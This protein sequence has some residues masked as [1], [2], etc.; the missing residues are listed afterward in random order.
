M[1]YR[2]TIRKEGVP[3]EARIIEAP[4][5]FAVYEQAQKE[6]GVVVE[7]I[8]EGDGFK[9]PAWLFMTIGTGVKR[10]EI[11]RMAKNLS[12]M[13]SA[14]LSLSRALSVI[15]RQSDNKR[16]RA[17]ATGISE[18]IKKGSS[19]HEALAQGQLANTVAP[20]EDEKKFLHEF[21]LLTL[22]P[23]LYLLN[24]KFDL[25]K[26]DFATSQTVIPAI[27]PESRIRPGSRIKF[28]MTPE[29]VTFD[30]QLYRLY[31]LYGLFDYPFTYLLFP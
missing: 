9:M 28:G 7:L 14:G 24:D 2:A 1:K 31:G 23:I 26:K 17:V 29:Y 18:S 27:E 16:L 6:D 13:L 8:E 30:F 21:P 22:K 25:E 5:R 20:S 4:S 11:I 3:D 19:F 10:I 15:E 12:A